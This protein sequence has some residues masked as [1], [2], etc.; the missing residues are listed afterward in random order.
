MPPMSPTVDAARSRRREATRVDPGA[1]T[2]TLP[3]FGATGRAE[4]WILL[5]VVGVL[6]GGLAWGLVTS[7]SNRA[8]PE[9]SR[10]SST[11]SLPPVT[12]PSPRPYK[13]L[14]GVN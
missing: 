11:T 14:A 8:A 5:V 4:I 13:V 7:D 12:L 2:G 10:R 6:G 1:H 9:P 3:G